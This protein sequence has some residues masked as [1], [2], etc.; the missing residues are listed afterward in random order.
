MA[1]YLVTYDLVG[2]DA[3][4]ENYK[5]LIAAIYAYTNVV[6]VQYSVWLLKSNGSAEA[7]FND[8]WRYMHS[9]DRLYVTPVDHRGFL[10]HPVDG[11][12][13]VRAFFAS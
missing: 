2:T 7:V 1:K 13:A 4:S 3:N 8:L 11:M 5:R 10:I 9:S 6:K 12:D